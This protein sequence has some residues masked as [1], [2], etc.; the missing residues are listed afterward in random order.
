MACSTWSSHRL[1]GGK[2]VATFAREVTWNG[3]KGQRY[4][5]CWISYTRSTEL[6]HKFF[7]G[8]S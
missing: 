6:V 3:S 5:V 4:I 8:P 2:I 7:D 1:S